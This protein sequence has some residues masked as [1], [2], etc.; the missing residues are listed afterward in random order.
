M[1]LTRKHHMDTI[2]DMKERVRHTAFALMEN[3]APTAAE[4]QSEARYLLATCL[5]ITEAVVE[6]R[7]MDVEAG[8]RKAKA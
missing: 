4:M 5:K 3:S 7:N 2:L 6:L 8:R 1:T